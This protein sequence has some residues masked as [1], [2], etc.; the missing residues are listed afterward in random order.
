MSR[1][2]FVMIVP[3]EVEEKLLDELLVSFST[4]VFTS[5]PTFTHGVAPS[6]LRADEQVLGRRR[7]M[8]VQVLVTPANAKR[9][10]QMLSEKFANAGL[11]YWILP[12][13]AE[14]DVL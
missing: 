8:Q 10:R 2:C 5:A 1:Y 14:G 6:D 13:I 7:A 4:D 3:L 9:L 12:V 11:H